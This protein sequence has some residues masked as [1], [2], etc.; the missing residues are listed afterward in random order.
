MIINTGYA[1]GSIRRTGRGG[2]GLGA[3]PQLTYAQYAALTPYQ[4][5]AFS[6]GDPNFMNA[7]TP[8][9]VSAAPGP[10]SST[11]IVIPAATAA[12]VA[13][14]QFAT[15]PFG[16]GTTTTYTL[17]SRMALWAA[18]SIA[19]PASLAGADPMS[20]ALA[21][22]QSYCAQE[23]PPD[24]N[25]LSAIASKYG[26]QVA[27][28]FA[29]S[30]AAGPLSP[31]AQPGTTSSNQKTSIV[32]TPRGTSH[33]TSVK[34]S[35]AALA[36]ARFTPPV[37]VNPSPAS[38]PVTTGSSISSPASVSSVANGSSL[39]TSS[40]GCVDANGNPIAC[41]STDIISGIPNGVLLI[42]GA[43]AVVVL[44]VAMGGK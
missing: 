38:Q 32:Y 26:A 10:A 12:L 21:Y 15:M 2:R 35:A 17:D 13:N 39:I 11:G 16:T 19:E 24:C 44:I 20:E 5:Q 25:Q 23:N 7:G 9:Y 34:Q 37:V 1:L 8:G 6:N 30:A 42:G 18:G 36:P 3:M 29:A 40:T 43:A 33:Q 27:A 41:P 22:A 14:P 4:Q 28:A 31:A